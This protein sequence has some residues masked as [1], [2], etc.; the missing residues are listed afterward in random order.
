MRTVSTYYVPPVSKYS[1]GIIVWP[2]KKYIPT[3]TALCFLRD[4][5]IC[6]Q[7]TAIHLWVKAISR[8]VFHGGLLSTRLLLCSAPLPLI[9]EA[10]TVS[11]TAVILHRFSRPTSPIYLCI[12]YLCVPSSS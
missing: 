8:F 11:P 6:D 7:F 9:I 3:T 2:R 12:L 4:S 5:Y 1:T 10:D